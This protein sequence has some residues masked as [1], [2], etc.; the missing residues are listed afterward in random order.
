M[1]QNTKMILIVVVVVAFLFI[2]FGSG[3]LMNQFSI[4]SGHQTIIDHMKITDTLYGGDLSVKFVDA[5]YLEWGQQLTLLNQFELETEF[6]QSTWLWQRHGD[7]EVAMTI[8]GPDL[9]GETY[10]IEC[11]MLG[12]GPYEIWFNEEKMLTLSWE[13]T[14]QQVW[15]F[16]VIVTA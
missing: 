9:T 10:Y 15:W 16:D 14:H 6:Y 3:S 13:E 8:W 12:A 5:G 4:P 1:K 2:G 11:A 7:T